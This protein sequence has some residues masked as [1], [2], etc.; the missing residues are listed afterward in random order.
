[1]GKTSGTCDEKCI[2]FTFELSQVW[3]RVKERIKEGGTNERWRGETHQS[4][5]VS[6]CHLVLQERK[7]ER[8]RGKD[9]EWCFHWHWFL[10][11]V[12]CSCFLFFVSSLFLSGLFLYLSLILCPS[13]T[14]PPLNSLFMRRRLFSPLSSCVYFLFPFSLSFFPRA[15]SLPFSL[16][17]SL[18]FHEFGVAVV[19]HFLTPLTQIHSF[20]TLHILNY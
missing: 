4:Q 7:R 12:W 5:V 10:C 20:F 2:L 17:L 1:M 9:A 3:E 13:S 18:S 11:A 6:G 16:F 15:F 8:E 19:E 14:S